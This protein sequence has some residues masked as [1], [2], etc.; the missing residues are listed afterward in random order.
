MGKLI[1]GNH[2]EALETGRFS[3]EGISC[4]LTFRTAHPIQIPPCRHDHFLSLVPSL[5]GC[6]ANRKALLTWKM[7]R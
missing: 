6:Q 3:L 5:A 1:Y 7:I 2:F 4:F